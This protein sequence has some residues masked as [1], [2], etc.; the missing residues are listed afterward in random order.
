MNLL[1]NILIF[2]YLDNSTKSLL[3]NTGIEFKE[4]S[5]F[6]N[7]E[8][9]IVNMIHEEKIRS[10]LADLDLGSYLRSWSDRYSERVYLKGTV[11][12]MGILRHSDVKSY[13]LTD[14][15]NYWK[16]SKGDL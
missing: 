5:S 6:E 14:G 10:L 2:E 7:E 4:V 13:D 16:F 11:I 12:G 8:Y 1:Q 9:L 15:N 3:S